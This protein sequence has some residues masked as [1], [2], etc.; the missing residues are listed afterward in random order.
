M[1]NWLLVAGA[2][3]AVLTYRDVED[4]IVRPVT[5][6]LWVEERDARRA[7]NS[8]AIAE[9]LIRRAARASR[10]KAKPITIADLQLGRELDAFTGPIS[11][12]DGFGAA[13]EDGH[14]AAKVDPAFARR[15]SGAAW[16]A[17][18]AVRLGLG[19]EIAP[20][21][22]WYR[23]TSGEPAREWRGQPL[24]RALEAPNGKVLALYRPKAGA[25]E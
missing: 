23:H 12:W 13:L 14:E 9:V 24:V 4:T 6:Q 16:R 20:G 1:S 17:W 25:G 19:R 18:L 21:A 11:A 3:V 2:A 15:A 5:A 8:Q 7:D 10:V 22:L